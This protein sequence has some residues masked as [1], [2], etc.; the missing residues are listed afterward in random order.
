MPRAMLLCSLRLLRLCA[1]LFD[2]DNTCRFAECELPLCVLCAL[3]WLN[4][5]LPLRRGFGADFLVDQVV[6]RLHELAR[7]RADFAVA[8]GFAVDLRG[9]HDVHG[10]AGDEHFVRAAELIDRH[11]LLA[12]LDAGLLCGL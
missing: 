7:D 9:G 2:S 12:D 1:R 3:L 8:Y 6:Q 11:S 10:R 5:L 4:N